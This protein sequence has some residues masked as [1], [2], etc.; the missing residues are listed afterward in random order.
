MKRVRLTLL[1]MA[2]ALGLSGCYVAPYGYGYGG[3]YRAHPPGYCYYHP[4]RCG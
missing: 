3:Y 2:T 1:L 4:Y